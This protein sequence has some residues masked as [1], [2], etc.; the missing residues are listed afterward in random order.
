MARRAQDPAGLPPLEVEDA[1][2]VVLDENGER[3]TEEHGERIAA[4]ERREVRLTE[5]Y[6]SRMAA[7]E[8]EVA[9]IV[10]VLECLV[11]SQDAVLEVL[12]SMGSGRPEEPPRWPH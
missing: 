6:S 10:R 2:R 5:A 11:Q 7:L 8:E 1:L 9:R 3:L 4:L 12:R